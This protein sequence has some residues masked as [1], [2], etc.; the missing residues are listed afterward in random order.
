VVFVRH[1]LPGE[2]VVVEITEGD[3]RSRFL[4]AD[5]VQILTASP[6]RVAAACP[7][8][9][10]GGCG[11]C[12]FQHVTLPAQRALLAGV[13]REQLRRL[14]G[15]DVPVSV[16]PVRGD[17]DGLD[18]RTR[19]RF[20]TD[21]LGRLGL[22]KH[23]SHEVVPLDDCPI[24]HPDLPR[25]LDHRWPGTA[26]VEAIASGCGDRL[27]VVQPSGGDAGSVPA[28]DVTGTV[29][30]TGRRLQGRTYVGEPALDRRWRVSATGFW[31]VHPGA[32]E[33]LVGAALEMLAPATAEVAL[34]L[35]SGVGLFAAA[36]AVGVGPDG[37]VLAVEGDARAVKDARRNL[38]DLPQVHLREGPVDRVLPEVS[39]R[40][41]VVLLDPPRT[42]VWRRVVEHVTRLRPRAVAYV[43]CDPAALAR[44]VATFAEHGY[45]LERLRAFDI[46]P[47]T[48]HVE[49]VALLT[50]RGEAE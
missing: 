25:V 13:V 38:H 12:D 33:T 48:H 43:A 45:V 9:R 11:G 16:E 2:H 29:S 14:A 10:P 42:G 22:R 15:L 21:E 34:D 17:R 30:T 1:A 5:A 39:G 23:R 44:D 4:R 46:F 8:A 36:L 19:V 35:Y 24:A 37:S 50:Q 20:A 49:C 47:M 3:E 7:V 27:V 18:W 6:D 40:V 26:S 32:A 31:Q 41:D 28:L